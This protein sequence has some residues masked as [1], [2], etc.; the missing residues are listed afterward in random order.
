[1]TTVVLK[2][3]GSVLADGLPAGL[4]GE[5]DR[6]RRNG[7]RTVLVHGGGPEV[8]RVLARLGGSS[9]FVDGLRV[10]DGGDMD[11]VEMVLA[12]RVNKVI[13]RRLRRSGVPAVGIAGVDGLLLTRP[14][15]RADRLGRVGEVERV[16]PGL[17]ETLLGAA[18]LPV[19]APVGADAEG[20]SHN[21][22]SDAAAAAVARAV[23]AERLVLVTDV[24]GIL[25]GEEAAEEPIGQLSPEGA[26]RLVSEGVVTR[27][28]MP[29]VEACLAAL[30][31][32]VRSAH[33][34][35]TGSIAAALRG[36]PPA[37]GGGTTIRSGAGRPA[38]AEA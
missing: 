5:L 29:K 18:Y 32:G 26:R 4:P 2:L 23:G 1:M 38:E 3:G 31:G 20:R 34:V 15:P 37:P 10:T 9:E 22:N 17:L 28:M 6:L 19:V 36:D 24:P 35:G 21:V 33:V 25:R 11:V 13:V 12:G 30:E 8:S 7:A 27:G 16:D 14:H